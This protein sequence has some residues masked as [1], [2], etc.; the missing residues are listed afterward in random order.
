MDGGPRAGNLARGWNAYAPAT[1]TN[2]NPA[3]KAVDGD[4]STQTDF[5]EGDTWL[6]VDIGGLYSIS[7]IVLWNRQDCCQ[8]RLSNALIRVGVMP[9]TG[10][11]DE[12]HISSNKL[13]WQQSGAGSP[14]VPFYTIL[15]SPPVIGRWVSVQNS[16][17]QCRLKNG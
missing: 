7:S 15:L 12:S 1:Y 9:L 13:V 11:N 2:D 6:S 14:L 3:G 4:S 17:E 16:G 8:E 5:T 10:S